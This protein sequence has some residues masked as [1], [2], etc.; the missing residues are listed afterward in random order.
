MPSFYSPKFRPI[1]VGWVL[2]LS[3]IIIVTFFTLFPT[4]TKP[5]L[6]KF[7][8]KLAEKVVQSVINYS[9]KPNSTAENIIFTNF[10]AVRRTFSEI[11]TM[12]VST[13][14]VDRKV[15]F[16]DMSLTFVRERLLHLQQTSE[17]FRLQVQR[18]SHVERSFDALK[19]NRDKSSNE[20]FESN[21]PDFFAEVGNWLDGTTDKY[22]QIMSKNIRECSSEMT[23]LEEKISRQIY[24]IQHGELCEKNTKVLLFRET[25][26][27]IFPE[28]Q[29]N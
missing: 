12:C 26:T 25:S 14:S 9:S 13:N 16:V 7:M 5:S 29:N 19:K 18:F 11:I 27:S 8:P 22:E 24:E 6:N 17:Q 1:S 3:S 23:R 4:S 10:G 20:A 2:V 21:L 28:D 15:N